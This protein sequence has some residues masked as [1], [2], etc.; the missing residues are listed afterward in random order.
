MEDRDDD[1]N[2]NNNNN[3]GTANRAVTLWAYID[4]RNGYLI[5]IG[6]ERSIISRPLALTFGT[7]T[8]LLE[9]SDKQQEKFPPMLAN[10][11][12]YC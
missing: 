5:D 6:F 4:E 3:H 11:L 9:A 7:A 2:N 12:E 8:K 10:A 1:D